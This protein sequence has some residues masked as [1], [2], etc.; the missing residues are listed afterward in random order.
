MFISLKI[1]LQQARKDIVREQITCFDL[2]LICEDLKFPS[3]VIL[4]K[5]ETNEYVSI[6]LRDLWDVIVLSLKLGYCLCCEII[7]CKFYTSEYMAV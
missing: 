5:L 4:W 3:A 1:Y 2:W 7:K 6:V